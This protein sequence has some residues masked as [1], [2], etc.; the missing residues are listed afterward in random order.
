M[1]G[2]KLEETEVSNNCFCKEEGEWMVDSLSFQIKLDEEPDTP[3]S[4]PE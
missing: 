4:T 2:F 1:L 3:K